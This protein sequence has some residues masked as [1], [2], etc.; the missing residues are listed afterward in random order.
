M[1]CSVLR[2]ILFCVH[3]GGGYLELVYRIHRSILRFDIIASPILDKP[4]TTKRLQI[5]VDLFGNSLWTY[6][7]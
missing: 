4:Y 3:N 1:S 2:C 6:L 5:N 7:L